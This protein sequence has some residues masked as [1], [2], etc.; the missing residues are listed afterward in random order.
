M[1]ERQVG[2]PKHVS[3]W[4][5]RHDRPYVARDERCQQA[6]FQQR[7]CTWQSQI[8]CYHLILVDYIIFSENLAAER[9]CNTVFITGWNW[10]KVQHTFFTC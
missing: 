1:A 6:T 5:G 7:F 8:H 9:I 10:T 4:S 3:L 2:K